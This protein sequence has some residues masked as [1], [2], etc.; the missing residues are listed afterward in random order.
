M[1]RILLLTLPSVGF[2][3]AFTA[4]PAAFFGSESAG[5]EASAA[6]NLN[7]SKSNIYKT[8]PP[9]KRGSQT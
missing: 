8:T 3:I 6:T 4:V 1:R 2:L 5:L 9:K 7:S